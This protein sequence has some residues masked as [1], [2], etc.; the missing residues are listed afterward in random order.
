[1]LTEDYVIVTHSL[2]LVKEHKVMINNFND[3]PVSLSP[4]KIAELLGLS[5]SYVYK[6]VS[7]GELPYY[8]IGKR[9][10]VMR[11]D[12]VEWL[13]AREVG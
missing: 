13:R 8:V 7:N 5:K 12:F 4:K 3:L 11:D 2:R 10:V 9:K 6:L 1:M